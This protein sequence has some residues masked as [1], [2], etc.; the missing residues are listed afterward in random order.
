MKFKLQH[1]SFLIAVT[2]LALAVLPDPTPEIT[3]GQPMFDRATNSFIAE[4]SLGD[5]GYAVIHFR[6]TDLASQFARIPGVEV[7]MR[8]PPVKVVRSDVVVEAGR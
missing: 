3:M 1:F 5:E 6:N 7:V 2:A 8:A 4:I